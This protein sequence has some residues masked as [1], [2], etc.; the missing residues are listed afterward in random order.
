[1]VPSHHD[2][3]PQRS[4]AF[5]KINTQFS[6]SS[7]T[8]RFGAICDVYDIIA[9]DY[10]QGDRKDKMPKMTN[11]YQRLQTYEKRMRND[12]LTNLMYEKR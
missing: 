10:Q 7:N 4:P 6:E 2:D 9:F 5:C 1:M 11:E 3:W 12:S 8:L